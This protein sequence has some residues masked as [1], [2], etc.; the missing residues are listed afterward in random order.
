MLEKKEGEGKEELCPP[1]AERRNYAVVTVAVT[2]NFQFVVF[3][4]H[5]LSS[6]VLL[7]KM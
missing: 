1:L 4:Q 3:L 6:P 2:D 5:S 7:D